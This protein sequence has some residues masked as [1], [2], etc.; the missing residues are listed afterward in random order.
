ML[1]LDG[2]DHFDHLRNKMRKQPWAVVLLVMDTPI[3][4]QSPMFALAS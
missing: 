4:G 2:S 3:D 1:L